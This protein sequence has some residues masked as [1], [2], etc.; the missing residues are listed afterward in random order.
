MPESRP[1]FQVHWRITSLELLE[2][3]LALFVYISFSI[4][5]IR[6]GMRNRR[7]PLQSNGRIKTG[8]VT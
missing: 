6:E 8:Q 3:R 7:I 2:K 4:I 1:D 5:P